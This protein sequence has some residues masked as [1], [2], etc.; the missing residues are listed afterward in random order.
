MASC[1]PEEIRTLT[2]GLEKC[3]GAW[4]PYD[5]RTTPDLGERF[6]RARCHGDAVSTP[7]PRAAPR[8]A[9]SPG[10][11]LATCVD[12]EASQNAGKLW[13]PHPD[14]EADVREAIESVDRGELLSPEGSE[15][16]LRWLEGADDESWRYLSDTS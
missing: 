3:H 16:F 7:L 4:F 9:R 15:A 5:S 13:K 2:G 8:L 11:G 6:E 1:A 12:P 14:D 10:S